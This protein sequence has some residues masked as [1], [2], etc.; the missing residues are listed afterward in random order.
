MT[1]TAVYAESSIFDDPV[2]KYEGHGPTKTVPLWPLYYYKI[3]TSKAAYRK[4]ILWPIYTRTVTPEQKVDQFFSFQNKYPLSF[5]KHTYFFWPLSGFQSDPDFGYNHWIFPIMWQSKVKG[6]GR[7][8][9]IFPLYWYYK[10]EDS[11]AHTLNIAL[12]NHNFWGPGYHNHL[13]LPIAWTKW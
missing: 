4:H 12:L 2:P 10:R 9:V 6:M 8:N 3:Y 1:A 7:Q 13:L 11:D 5:S